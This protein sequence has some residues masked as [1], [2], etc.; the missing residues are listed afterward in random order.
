MVENRYVYQPCESSHP[1][2][3]RMTWMDVPQGKLGKPVPKPDDVLNALSKIKPS[4]S[5][6]DEAKFKDWTEKFGSHG[7]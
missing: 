5:A 3:C 1:G 7:S 4:L 6:E 2:A